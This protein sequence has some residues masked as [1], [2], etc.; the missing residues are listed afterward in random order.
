MEFFLY[1]IR[2]ERK[3]DVVQQLQGRAHSDLFVRK[4]RG[5]SHK[6]CEHGP[7]ISFFDE[8][9]EHFLRRVARCQQR[10]CYRSGGCSEQAIECMAPFEE[11]LTSSNEDHA[12]GPSTFEYEVVLHIATP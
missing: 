4:G 3:V 6:T 7:T 2:Q 12:L 10:C 11:L 9:F 5:R 1:E 8:R